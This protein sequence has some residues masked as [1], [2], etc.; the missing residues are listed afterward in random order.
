[1]RLQRHGRARNWTGRANRMPQAMIGVI[2]VIGGDRGMIG[3]IDEVRGDGGGDVVDGRGT[4]DERKTMRI[5]NKT[6]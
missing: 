5:A 4:V 3:V 2:E 6:V 1:M